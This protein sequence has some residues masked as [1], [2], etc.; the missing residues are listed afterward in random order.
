M[1]NAKKLLCI[2][3]GAAAIMLA[4]CS[5]SEQLA[6]SP[7][8]PEPSETVVSNEPEAQTAEANV[9]VE[10]EA[11]VQKIAKKTPSTKTVPIKT[12]VT[13]TSKTSPST[14]SAPTTKHISMTAAN[15]AFSPSN[16]S[17]KKGDTVI[18]TITGKEGAHGIAI[19]DFKISKAI[20]EGGTVIVQ[21]TADKTGIFNFFCNIPCGSG[22]KD[23]KGT[24]TVS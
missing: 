21:F 22:H 17:V 8:T 14:T 9:A 4:G 15:F 19:P 3:I 11:S 5:K 10:T 2:G 6:V 7:S 1:N 18:L 13:S 12:S 20:T 16:I 23:M 24:I